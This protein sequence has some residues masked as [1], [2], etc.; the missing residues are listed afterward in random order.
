MRSGQ[1]NC[2]GRGLQ[3]QRVD[4]LDVYHN[5]FDA[6]AGAALWIDPGNTH[7]AN[8]V[9]Q[10]N[11]I[12]RDAAWFLDIRVGKLSGFAS[13]HNVFWDAPPA[14]NQQ[15]FLIDGQPL[16]IT[17]WQQKVGGTAVLAADAHSQVDDPHF[18]PGAP[19]FTDYYTLPEPGSPVRDRALPN[20]SSHFSGAG[21]DIG[22]RETYDANADACML[23]AAGS[24]WP[25]E[26]F[27]PQPGR[28]TADIDAIP[29]AML[30]DAA[31]GFANGPAA[32]WTSLAAIVRFNPAGRIDAR[33]GGQYTS[34][35]PIPYA[36]GQRYRLRLAVDVAAHR[37]SAWVTPPG[38]TEV[39]IGDNLAFRTEQQTVTSLRRSLTA[40]NLRVSPSGA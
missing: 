31:V 28:F 35:S 4:N 17:Q 25:D 19:T 11:N 7:K 1:G 2:R 27:N 21:P 8:N 3:L 5:T 39:R 33:N 36:A 24:Q 23:S 40:C 34:E 14:A 38:G 9:E 18:V 29:S 6:L 16:A 37:Y 22:F 20:V 26:P 10:W 12:V 15:R 32:G 30:I 13:D